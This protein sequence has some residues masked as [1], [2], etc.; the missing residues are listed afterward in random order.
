MRFTFACFLIFIALYALSGCAQ[1]QM[2]CFTAHSPSIEV[3]GQDGKTEVSIPSRVT[4]ICPA[5][6]E[7]GK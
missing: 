7:I 2:P 4:K 5:Y 6:I 1:T 3:I